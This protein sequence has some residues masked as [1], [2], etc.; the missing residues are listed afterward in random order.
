MDKL[1][2]LKNPLSLSS[3][4]VDP[5]PAVLTALRNNGSAVVLP[6][7]GQNMY[8]L[9]WGNGFVT[10]LDIINS[11]G[12]SDPN[13]FFQDLLTKPY[14]NSVSSTAAHAS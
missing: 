14:V 11:R 4:A 3:H 13:D 1:L 9:N 5:L 10:N 2:C 6:G 7:T 8:G 12:L